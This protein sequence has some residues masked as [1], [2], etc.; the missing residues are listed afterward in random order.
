MSEFLTY[1]GK[2]LVRSKNVIYYGDMSGL[3]VKFSEELNVEVLRER[4][5]DEHAIGVIG[6]VELDAKVADQQKIAV[7]KMAAS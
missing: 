5:A 3:A 4:F 7:L 1:K 6:W 2:P